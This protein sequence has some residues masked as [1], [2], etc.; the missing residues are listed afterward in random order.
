MIDVIIGVVDRPLETR[1][2]LEALFKANDNINVILVDDGSSEFVD[3]TG[4]PSTR[5]NF[6]NTGGRV[7]QA[8]SVNI[9][10]DVSTSEYVVVMHNDIVINDKGW[11]DKAVEFLKTHS[12]AGLVSDLGWV[13]EDG[14]LPYIPVSTT[15]EGPNNYCH[16]PMLED[17]VEVYNTDNITSVFK[18][19]GLRADERYGLGSY[20]LW[21]DIKAKGLKV[22]VMKFENSV[23]SVS[24]TRNIKAYTDITTWKEEC[25]LM[26]DIVQKRMIE[27][28]IVMPKH[29]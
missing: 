18:N 3:L 5:I 17:F 19:D 29:R 1:Q 15:K 10:L 23:H 16:T 7:G 8:K 4:L 20:S 9:G 24:S 27:F 6:I 21:V 11:I 25:E 14:Y 22:Y 13:L 28:G 2:T 26:T 12:N